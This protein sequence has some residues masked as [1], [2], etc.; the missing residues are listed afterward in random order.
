MSAE[1]GDDEAPRDRA[2]E[3]LD[4]LTE[5]APIQALDVVLLA[6]ATTR[7]DLEFATLA[8]GP[9]ENLVVNQGPAVIDRIEAVAAADAT[10][11][12]LLSGRSSQGTSGTEIWRRV[13][14]AVGSGP[15]IDDDPRTRPG[16][17]VD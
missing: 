3:C 11:R 1:T 15:W 14:V 7:T 4:D 13:Q 17:L 6:M 16:G 10:F 12:K 5:V 8:A 9:P 2:Y